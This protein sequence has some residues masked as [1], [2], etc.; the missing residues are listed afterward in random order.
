MVTIVSGRSL[1]IKRTVRASVK[2]NNRVGQVGNLHWFY[3]PYIRISFYG[4]SSNIALEQTAWELLAIGIGFMNDREV[5]IDSARLLSISVS[6]KMQ[7]VS[8]RNLFQ[9]CEI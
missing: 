5:L 2:K 7:L 1:K 8:I 6:W 4:F 3:D 9:D